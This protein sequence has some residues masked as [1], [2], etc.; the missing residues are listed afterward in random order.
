M[1][2]PASTRTIAGIEIATPSPDSPFGVDENINVTTLDNYLDIDGV[3][4]RD[5]RFLEDPADYEAIG[6]SSLMNYTVEGFRIVPFPLIATLPPMPVE[7]TYT[8]DTLFSVTWSPEGGIQDVTPNYAQSMTIVEELFPKDGPLFLMCGGGGYAGLM[9]DFLVH[10]GWDATQV[11]NL[12]G[13]WGYTGEHAVP[14][15][16]PHEDG[17]IE[18]CLWRA[19]IAPIIFEDLDPIA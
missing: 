9:R 7:G 15:L 14:L 19:D 18:R 10:L 13:A 12:G 11:Y 6:G 3:T 5:M 1:S 17:T 8:G 4:Y 16:T 2:T